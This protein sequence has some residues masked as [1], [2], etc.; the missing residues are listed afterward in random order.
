MCIATKFLTL[1][2]GDE[3]MDEWDAGGSICLDELMSVGRDGPIRICVHS[4]YGRTYVQ[5]T[6]YIHFYVHEV[7]RTEAFIGK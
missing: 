6:E 1:V 7:D 5:S 4:T 2:V 3:R